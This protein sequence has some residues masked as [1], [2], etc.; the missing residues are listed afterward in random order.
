MNII[1]NAFG[2][3][4]GGMEVMFAGLAKY[5][6]EKGFYVYFL[7]LNK[8]NNIYM[9]MLGS[10]NDKLHYIFSFDKDILYMTK[11]DK[12]KQKE[13]VNNQL[14]RFKIDYSQ[15]LIL[16]GYYR[17]LLTINDIFSNK[18]NA[19]FL[20]VWPHPMDW[21]HYLFPEPV[22]TYHWEKLK[23]N[24][25]YQYQK[26]LLQEVENGNA[27]YFTS[28]AIADYNKW[29][30]EVSFKDR[31]IEGLP[32]Q[33]SSG[34]CFNY[35]YNENVKKLSFVWVGRFDYFK[36]D[37]ILHTV[38][39]LEQIKTKYP[40]Y[41]IVFN[42]YG[43]G[44]KNYTK[45]ITENAKSNLIQIN[46]FGTIA[47]DKLNEVFSQNDIGIG[48]GVTVKQ[49]GYSG[50]P[51]ILIDSINDSYRTDKYCNWVSDIATGDDGD[52][53]YYYIAGNQLM[54]RK[55][56]F[57][58]I[59]DVIQNPSNLNKYSKSCKEYVENNY[60]CDKQY[61]CI[62]D[63]AINSNYHGTQLFTYSYPKNEVMK[64]N[65]NYNLRKI[66]KKILGKK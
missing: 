26:K 22:R 49:M 40:E 55:S 25:H 53:F 4:Y 18:Q 10:E 2:N 9:K 7:T 66:V 16:A 56:L 60:D 38:K 28:Y 54:Y 13:Y 20:F 48:M 24:D 45:D 63:R 36:N 65:F 5:A 17:D 31:K 46:I 51:A 15:T 11:K 62:I 1:I 64:Y 35:N 47:P 27:H 19:R 8:K 23:N 3:G 39:V 52:G 41:E 50:L 29:Y 21:I 6:I 58:L 37:A 33:K 42:I 32:I 61:Q 44:N 57:E 30:Y 34:I 12:E 59:E 14:D 43:R